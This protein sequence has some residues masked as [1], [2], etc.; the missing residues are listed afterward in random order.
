M[1]NDDVRAFHQS[2]DVAE[3]LLSAALVPLSQPDNVRLVIP[4]GATDSDPRMPN[5]GLVVDVSVLKIA[6]V[7]IMLLGYAVEAFNVE[8]KDT[9]TDTIG[10]LY[11]EGIS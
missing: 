8:D 7:P 5:D 4:L 11:A 9:V 10:Y 6:P 1:A 2:I 3:E